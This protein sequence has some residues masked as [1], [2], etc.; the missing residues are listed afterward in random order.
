MCD[1]DVLMNPTVVAYVETEIV[2]NGERLRT[3]DVADACRVSLATARKTLLA[4]VD[5]E[6]LSMVDVGTA[7]GMQTAAK[8]KGVNDYRFE[9]FVG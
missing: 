6:V 5:A 7:G 4:L 3:R 9:R 8:R 2:Q 1:D